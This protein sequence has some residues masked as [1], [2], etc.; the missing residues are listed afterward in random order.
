MALV[1]TKIMLKKALEN[2]FAIPAFNVCNLET[3]KAVI[4]ASEDLNK[5]AIIS[6]SEGAISYAGLN[7]IVN[8]VKTLAI[9]SKNDFALHLDH[10]KSVDLCKKAIDSGFTSVMFDGSSLPYDENVKQTKQV[11]EY[12][13]NKNVSVEAELGKILGLEDMINNSNEHFTDPEEALD[14]ITKTQADSLAIS[15]GTAHGINKGVKKPE[16]QFDVIESVHK[17]IPTTPLVAHGSS[18]VPQNLVKNINELGGTINKSQGIPDE[19]I[20]KMAKS[21]IC[22]INIDTDLRLAFTYGIRK[23]LTDNPENFDPRKYLKSGIDEVKNQV[24]AIFNLLGWIKK[25]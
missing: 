19:T 6:V 12:A 21:P 10:G 24:K 25:V 14:F 3:A 16:I 18:S 9:N 1:N 7:Q 11:V 2:N 23:S 20:R 17:L 4:S 8:I 5:D 22:K 15:I 13:H